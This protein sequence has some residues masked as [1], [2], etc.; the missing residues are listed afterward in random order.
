MI[1]VKCDHQTNKASLLKQQTLKRGFTL[2]EI[3]MSVMILSIG[4]GAISQ[5]VSGLNMA[6]KSISENRRAIQISQLMVERIQGASW[7]EIGQTPW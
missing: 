3:M 5:S 6:N 2:I 4:L 7:G 1:L